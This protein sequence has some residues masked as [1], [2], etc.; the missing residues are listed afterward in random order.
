MRKDQIQNIHKGFTTDGTANEKGTGIGLALCRDFL[1]KNNGWFNVS[2][3]VDKGST[4]TFTVPRRP[5]TKRK[6][7]ELVKE[8]DSYSLLNI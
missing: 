8:E 2:S 5:L 4:F 6:F 7:S 3:E 1:S